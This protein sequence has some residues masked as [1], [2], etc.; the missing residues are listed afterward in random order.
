M[1]F[2]VEQCF[3]NNDARFTEYG[4]FQ[5]AKNSCVCI[6]PGLEHL[7]VEDDWVAQFKSMKDIPY[8]LENVEHLMQVYIQAVYF[9]HWYTTEADNFT[10]H[11]EFYALEPTV[12]DV[13]IR[14]DTPRF[15]RLNSVS[16][17]C[18]APVH[19]LSEAREIIRSSPRCDEAIQ[20]A[21]HYGF[22]TFIVMRAWKDFS[23]GHEYRCFIYDDRLTAITKHDDKP[24]QFA[25]EE[26]LV[27]RIQRLLNAARYFLPHSTICM[28]CF[29]H[30]SDVAEDCVVEF[31]AYGPATDTGPGAFHWFTDMWDLMN[32]ETVSVRLY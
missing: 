16:P 15:V 31:S 17:K 7:F 28:D 30:N 13:D 2:N 4:E 19:S 32:S 23:D 25:N 24:R 27:Q 5:K 1:S 21:T 12:E 14:W 11:S 18:K 9:E 22:P 6:P 8:S 3:R 29:V 20:N 26:A 10:M